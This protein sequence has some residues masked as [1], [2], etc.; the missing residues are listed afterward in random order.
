MLDP[1]TFVSGATYFVPTF[2]PAFLLRGKQHYHEVVCLDILRAIRI[3][4]QGGWEQTAQVWKVLP[5]GG[6]N[7]SVD[8]AVNFIEENYKARRPVAL[9]TETYGVGKRDALDQYS[10]RLHALGLSFYP[11]NE[12]VSFLAD[13]SLDKAG[14]ERLLNLCRQMIADKELPKIFFNYSYDGEVL[15]R[16]TLPVGGPI[17]DCLVLHHITDPELDHD[18]G[19][20][21]QQFLDTDPW[22][23]EYRKLERKGL[24][25]LAQLLHYNGRDTLATQ[26]LFP[27]LGQRVEELDQGHIAAYETRTME[28]AARMGRVGIPI[29]E[30]KRVEIAQKLQAMRDKALFF[31]RDKM[32]W[33]DFDPKKPAHRRELVYDRLKLPVRFYTE[34]KG[35]P[36]TGIKALITHLDVDVVRALVDFDESHKQLSTFVVKLPDIVDDFGRLHVHWKSFGTVGSRWASSPNAQNWPKWLRA[37]VKTRPGRILVGADSKAI[38]YRLIAVLSGCRKLLDA[39]N[40]PTRDVHSEVAA[41]VFGTSF[42]SLVKKSPAWTDM[43]A[44]AKRVVYARNYRAAP[45]TICENIKNDPKTPVSVRST[46]TPAFIGMIAR[47]FDRAFPEIARWCEQEWDKANRLGYQD[48][49]PLGRKRYHYVRP[50]E[51]TVAAN[52]PVQFAAGD[53][54]NISMLAIDE[55]LRDKYPT[56]HLVLNVHDQ[57]VVECDTKDAEEINTLVQDKMTHKVEGPNGF[58]MLEGDPG[59]ADNWEKV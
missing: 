48:V 35:E 39:F 33:F 21:S 47:N 53:F 37:I 12:A 45:E 3:A 6:G 41:E 27:I 49:I 55:V 30:E 16:H 18:L 52:N 26:Q 43:R 24:G 32:A 34:K 17:Y 51:P 20:V 54:Q 14:T 2:H 29:S 31:I 38:E 8:G 10:C 36:M 1:S 19:F 58:V 7:M 28:L 40:D 25:T 50:V 22:K 42:T 13:G 11:S 4:E 59:I 46:L 5:G 15:L 44:I 56:A 9:D 23:V 57:I